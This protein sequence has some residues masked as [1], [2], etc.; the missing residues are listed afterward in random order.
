MS[1][2][3]FDY[4]PLKTIASCLK[5]MEENSL[6]MSSSRISPLGSVNPSNPI[7]LLNQFNTGMGFH[8][9]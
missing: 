8:I 6:D 4:K 5:Y 7:L 2:A 9:F 3:A 1:D